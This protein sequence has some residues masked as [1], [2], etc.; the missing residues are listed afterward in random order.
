MTLSERIIAAGP[1]V[2]LLVLCFVVL[3]LGSAVAL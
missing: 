1:G 2:A 3:A